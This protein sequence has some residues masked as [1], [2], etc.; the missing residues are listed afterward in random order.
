MKSTISITEA[1][2]MLG[3]TVKTMQRCDRRALPAAGTML[4]KRR[5]YITEQMSEFPGERITRGKRAPHGVAYYRVSSAA[6]KR[7]LTQL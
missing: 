4:T 1:A 5:I 2:R 3:V 6:Q 7:E